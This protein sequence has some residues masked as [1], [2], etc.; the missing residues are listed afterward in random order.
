V[1]LAAGAGEGV[2][3]IQIEVLGD[4]DCYAGRGQHGYQKVR[5]VRAKAER[6]TK[7]LEKRTD[8]SSVLLRSCSR[9]CSRSIP[10]HEM[11]CQ[12]TETWHEASAAV[13]A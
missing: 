13:T 1:E 11:S 4:R 5:N 9:R 8:S 12:A 2:K 3:I 7:C 10:R 6:C